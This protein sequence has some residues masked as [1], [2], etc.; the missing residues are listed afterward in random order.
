MRISDLLIRQRDNEK[1]AINY[2][3]IS[4]TYSDWYQKSKKL[5]RRLTEMNNSDLTNIAICLPNSTSYAIAYFGITFMDSIIVPIYYKAKGFEILSTI[6]TCDINLVITDSQLVSSFY[7]IR[8]ILTSRLDLYLIDKD[9]IISLKKDKSFRKLP[10]QY[11]SIKNDVALMLQTSGTT[12]NPKRVMLTHR[13][14]I[15]NIEANIDSLNLSADDNVL[16]ALPMTFG[17]CNTS[18]FLTHLYLGACIHIYSGMFYPKKIFGIIE[19]E[20][21]TNFTGVPTMLLMLL[22]YRYY[23]N[24]DLST[25]HTITFGGS[26]IP[27]DKLTELINRYPDIAFIHT[28]GQT[29]CSPRVTAL[30]KEDSIRKLGSVGKPLKG[31]SVEIRGENNECCLP[32]EIGTIYVTGENVMKGYFKNEEATMLTKN[33]NW[34]NTGD[35]GY[36]DYERYLFITGREKN[37]IIYDGINIYPEEVEE[38]ILNIPEVEGVIIYGEK[39][40]LHGEVPI[41]KVVTQ[42][43]ISLAKI[44]ETCSDELA[45]YKIPKRIELVDSLPKTYNGK[46]RR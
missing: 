38:V 15:S 36:F 24:Y 46:I 18:Q 8:E 9:K 35:K 27:L 13:N 6:K 2:D 5:A 21:I 45:N 1:I 7:E 16:I 40:E 32:N 30:L 4:L 10:S 33:G 20:K 25:L 29:E 31:I 23:K 44:I 22:N 41:A 39:H 11:G 19:S 42:D 17:Y 14:L 34:I 12:S 28:Y 43:E 26:G 37:I 3:Q